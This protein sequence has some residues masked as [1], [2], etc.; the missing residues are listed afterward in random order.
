[1][2]PSPL[3][4]TYDLTYVARLVE[5]RCPALAPLRVHAGGRG[6]DCDVFF[7]EETYV[8]RFARNLMAARSL[9]LLAQLLPTIASALPLPIP[10][11]FAL[12]EIPEREGLCFELYPRLQ[13]DTLCD[14]PS[15]SLDCMRIAEQLGL[16]L[17]ALHGLAPPP[18]C[19]LPDDALGRLDPARRSTLTRESL[20]ALERDRLLDRE[21]GS[22]LVAA[23]EAAE[24]TPLPARRALVHGDLHDCNLLV[25]QGEL[26]AVLDWV[27][28]HIGH[29][30]VDL[31]VAFV[32]LPTA[33]QRARLFAAYGGVSTAITRWSRWRAI[34][35]LV[36]GAVGARQRDDP[37]MCAMCIDT[38]RVI[39]SS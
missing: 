14:L 35:L 31:A 13:G 11:P 20:R 25:E 24:A 39:A 15:A 27:D 30:A 22:A 38:L 21:S 10:Q 9:R 17:R 3:D 23:L 1:M 26:S 29:P 33:A 4:P 34:V 18:G 36:A 12:G 6:W 5:G 32:V 37:R 19:A 7:L 16:F 28:V 8:A 2:L